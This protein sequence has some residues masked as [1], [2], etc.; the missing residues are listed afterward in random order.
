MSTVSAGDAQSA[1][2]KVGPYFATPYLYVANHVLQA[3]RKPVR[4]VTIE[5]PED[6]VDGGGIR[7]PPSRHSKV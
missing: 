7:R 1:T 2:S 4:R 5:A 6:A 3:P